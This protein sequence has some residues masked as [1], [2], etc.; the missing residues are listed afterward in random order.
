MIVIE[1]GKPD[2]QLS[3]ERDSWKLV[4]ILINYS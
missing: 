2:F 3:I 4:L 1:R